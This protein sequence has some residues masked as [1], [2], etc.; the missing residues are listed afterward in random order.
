MQK[1]ILKRIGMCGIFKKKRMESNNKQ[2][3]KN[4]NDSFFLKKKGLGQ[5]WAHFIASF[6][7]L[8]L[9]LSSF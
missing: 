7:F 4:I 1:H 8:F 6:S 2:K 3:N 9:F 5:K